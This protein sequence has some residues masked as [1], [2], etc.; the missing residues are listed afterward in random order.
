MTRLASE[1]IEI[2]RPFRESTVRLT[3]FVNDEQTKVW[4]RKLA[5]ILGRQ[6]ADAWTGYRQHGFGRLR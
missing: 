3:V 2:A 5:G 6:L 1:D 4:F